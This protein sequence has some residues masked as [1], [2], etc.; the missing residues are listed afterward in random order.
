MSVAGGVGVIP[1]CLKN[2]YIIYPQGI[3][4][5]GCHT[6]DKQDIGKGRMVITSV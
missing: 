1:T 3:H 4:Q 6:S 2:I 5:G